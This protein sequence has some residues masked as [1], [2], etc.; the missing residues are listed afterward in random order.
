MGVLPKK[1]SYPV[2]DINVSGFLC[3]PEGQAAC[4]AV[5]IFHGSDGF[6]PNHEMIARKL[7]KEGYA[8]LALTWF[9]EASPR[10]QW[11]EVRADDILPAVVFLEQLPMV[12][13]D[14]L[15]LI[16][17][18]RGGGLALIMASLIPQTK[19]VVNYFGLTAWKNGM[20]EFCHLPLNQ[21]EHL[22]FVKNISCPILSFHG[23]KDMVVPVDNTIELDTTC[24]KYG[25][26]HTYFLYPDVDHSF[27]WYGDKYNRQVHADTWAKTLLFL[28]TNLSVSH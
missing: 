19:A 14:K 11:S 16:G 7:A 2:A 18:S 4:A 27:I 15:G 3:L 25:V 13:A 12:D 26:D 20:E 1:I 21:S 24:K 9:G 22:D 5:I 10:A 23:K 28:K 17:F 8:A 6:K